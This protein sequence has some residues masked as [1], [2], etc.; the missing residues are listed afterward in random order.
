MFKYRII[1]VI[2]KHI[3]VTK[4]DNSVKKCYNTKRLNGGKQNGIKNNYKS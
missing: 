3:D 1:V 2:S 4:L